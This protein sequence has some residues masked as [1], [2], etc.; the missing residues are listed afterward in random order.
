MLVKKKGVIMFKWIWKI[1]DYNRL[2]YD[3]DNCHYIMADMEKEIYRLCEQN[4]RLL[5]ELDKLKSQ[6]NKRIDP[7][8]L[9]KS[10]IAINYTKSLINNYCDMYVNEE[11]ESRE[12]MYLDNIIS[13]TNQLN[14]LKK[15]GE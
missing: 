6:V 9:D 11:D 5:T 1:R 3:L 2:D 4:K 10:V 12:L 14:L 7:V 15:K 8:T 13:L